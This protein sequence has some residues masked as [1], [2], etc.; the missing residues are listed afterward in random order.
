MN[1]NF[2]NE[3][4][5]NVTRGIQLLFCYFHYDLHSNCQPQQKKIEIQK[6]GGVPITIPTYIKSET[7]LRQTSVNELGSL[8]R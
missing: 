3:F 8:I 4:E 6:Y 2:F 1:N 7:V 5:N